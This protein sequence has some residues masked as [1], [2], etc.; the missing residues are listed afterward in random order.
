MRTW[1]ILRIGLINGGVLAVPLY[2]A[3]DPRWGHIGVAKYHVY[4]DMGDADR[5]IVLAFVNLHAR[6][7]GMIFI[8]RK[9][10]LTAEPPLQ[11]TII[12]TRKVPLWPRAYGFELE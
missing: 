11:P 4:I 12:V 7:F 9:P 3:V 1:G 6:A 8:Q 10:Y 5:T 2:E